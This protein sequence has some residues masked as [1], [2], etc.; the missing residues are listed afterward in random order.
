MA[1]A[2]DLIV[3]VEVT[4]DTRTP[5][6]RGFGTPLLVGYHT[7]WLD[8]V[9]EY[10]DEGE[11][12]DDGFTTDDYLYQVVKAMKAQTPSPTTIKVGRRATAPTQ[13]V[14]LIP[15]V[16]TAGFVH[17]ITVDGVKYSVTVQSAD[18][19][20][21]I[22][23]DFVTAMAEAEGVTVTDGTT[24]VVVTSDDAGVIHSFVAKIGMDLLDA[25]TE[26]GLE[27]DLNAIEEEDGDWYGVLLDCNSAA[28]IDELAEWIE[29]RVAI[30]V[31]QS[32]DW[33]VKDA[34]ED[35]DIASVMKTDAITRT[36]GIFHRE[37]GT[38]AA[39]A[40]MAKE[41]PK[42]P[43]QSTWAHKTLA[44]IGA[45]KL[46]T[47]EKNA[48]NGKNWSWYATVGGQNITFEGKTP[49]GEFLDIMHQV[50][51]STTRV[52]EA[53]FGM[54]TANDKIPQTDRGIEMA[55]STVFG[56]LKQCASTDFPIFDESTIVVDPLTMN[57]IAQADRAN[58]VLRGIKYQAR[59]QGAFHR[60]IVKGRVYV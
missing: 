5:S 57:D 11:M 2:L 6:Q 44:T 51:F 20:A 56:V 60:V 22:C 32:A 14:H 3:N 52:K 35:D 53:L 17:E 15:R 12:L 40:W 34:G 45:N 33:N 28:H 26:S 27:N 48:I 43:G 47:G 55:R 54:F 46:T 49:A 7:A 25:T 24:H 41:L 1:D 9:R 10:A 36:G 58:R 59:L 37:I 30:S 23:D 42:N 31:V 18:A 16:T 8:R 13:V 50:D 19:V 29:S 38:P 4:R 21:D 39:A